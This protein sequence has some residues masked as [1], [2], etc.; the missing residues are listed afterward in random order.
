MRDPQVR[1]H[2]FTAQAPDI[3][4]LDLITSSSWFFAQSTSRPVALLGSES[5][6]TLVHRLTVDAARLLYHT[7]RHL[8][9]AFHFARRDQLATGLAPVGVHPCWANKKKVA[10][11][12]L[13]SGTDQYQNFT[14]TPAATLVILPPMALE[15]M[16]ALLAFLFTA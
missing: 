6:P 15:E 10:R 13:E 7:G 8:A 16:T 11:R 9:V 1:T 2:A 4:Q 12:L 5:S 14:C 3:H